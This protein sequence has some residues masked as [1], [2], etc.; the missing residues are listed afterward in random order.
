VELI[1]R[2]APLHD[3][4]KLA[5]PDAILLKPYKPAWSLERA[6]EEI[7]RVAGSQLDPDVVQAFDRLDHSTLLA[8]IQT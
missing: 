7:Q 2:S 4:G 1:Q 8:P 5:V 3:V 6:V